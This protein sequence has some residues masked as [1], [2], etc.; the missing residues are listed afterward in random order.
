[1]R[2]RLTL[3]P[4]ELNAP[5]VDRPLSVGAFFLRKVKSF[6]PHPAIQGVYS[7]IAARRPSAFGVRY[8]FDSGA[9]A[10]T[11]CG[12]GWANR[13]H[14]S[15]V[16][17]RQLHENCRITV[18]GLRHVAIAYPCVSSTHNYY[19]SG[20]GL[21]QGSTLLRIGRSNLRLG[22]RICAVHYPVGVQS[23]DLGVR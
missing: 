4:S 23:I 7:S 22:E 16:A 10:D 13:R 18:F 3:L 17:S 20:A 11:A 14:R 19:Y 12:P 21:L 2:E 6:S 15:Q 5:A 9:K 1:M 8:G